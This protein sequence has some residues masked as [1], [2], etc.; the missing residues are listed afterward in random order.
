MGSPLQY[1][2]RMAQNKRKPPS[3]QPKKEKGALALLDL[4]SPTDGGGGGEV[5]PSEVVKRPRYPSA[6]PDASTEA[7]V[8]AAAADVQAQASAAAVTAEFAEEAAV[9]ARQAQAA[10]AVVSSMYRPTGPESPDRV[11][12]SPF[13]GMPD[14]SL[15]PPPGLVTILGRHLG[16]PV[17]DE[18]PYK[19]ARP[20]HAAP[21]EAMS[22]A[23]A[24]ALDALMQEEAPASARPAAAPDAA[25]LLLEAAEQE[26][27]AAVSG[28]IGCDGGCD[29]WFHLSEVGMTQAEA[30]ANSTW[31]C[32]TCATNNAPAAA[33]APSLPALHRRDTIPQLPEPGK[34]HDISTAALF[35]GHLLTDCL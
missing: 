15:S 20:P 19:G 28:M 3:W 14:D 35:P 13:E 22:A 11:G 29:G 5:S 24:A 2:Y 10:A 26:P 30:D 21:P 9:K 32:E 33:A 17:L 34:T 6:S 7:A 31:S 25:A 8:A 16:S 23:A 27:D 1:R 18:L 12:T 4:L